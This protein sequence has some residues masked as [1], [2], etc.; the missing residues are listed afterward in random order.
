MS[1]ALRLSAF[2]LL[3][4]AA[5]CTD[6]TQDLSGPVEPL[7]DFKLGFSEVVAPNIQ[8]LLVSRDASAEEWTTLLDSALETRFNRFTGSKFYH[9]GVSVEGYS[10]PPPIVPGKSYLA[11]R[12]TVW[13]DQAQAKLNEEPEL[14]LNAQVFESR[15]T[16]SREETMQRLVEG[17]AKLIEEWLREQQAEAGWFMTPVAG[18]GAAEAAED[19]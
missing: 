10:L 14:I 5:A 15:I 17:T 18:T 16:T 6:A 8:Q 7:G 19:S 1:I 13:D 4:S 11:V 2:V 3:L 12:V 9:L